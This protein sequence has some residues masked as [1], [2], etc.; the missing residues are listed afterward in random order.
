MKNTDKIL[1][2]F[3]NHFTNEVSKRSLEF[4]QVRDEYSIK[5][6]STA[7]ELLQSVKEKLAKLSYTVLKL[8]C[9]R[10][11]NR[12]EVIRDLCR[13]CYNKFIYRNKNK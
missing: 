5:Q 11:H 9:K 10:Y 3:K 12:T 1:N 6:L 13:S 7:N 2:L 4:Q 8:I